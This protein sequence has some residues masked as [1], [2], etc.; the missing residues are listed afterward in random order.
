MSR[1]DRWGRGVV[2]M[3]G[4]GVV[5]LVSATDVSA[6]A[7]YVDAKATQGLA[8]DPLPSPAGISVDIG[9][10]SLL[11]PFG[12]HAGFRNLYEDEPGDATLDCAEVSCPEGPVEQ[13]FAM[14]SVM[15]GLSYDFRN[16]TDVYMNLG[17]NGGLHWQIDKVTNLD[18]GSTEQ[19]E[20]DPDF[21]L[22][23]SLDLRLRPLVGPLRPVLT[24][25]YDRIFGESCTLETA[26]R[27][28]RS[29]WGFS[30]GLSWI[31][32]SPR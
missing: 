16:P 7:L 15:F 9:R 8:N 5:T 19:A 27:P 11:G 2:L 26:C 25:R 20:S 10:T 12:L 31:L 29:V 1:V 24:A 32:S 6:Q 21:S 14:R 23:L 30:A 28:D 4:M 3:L 13:S 18:S 22:G 17:F